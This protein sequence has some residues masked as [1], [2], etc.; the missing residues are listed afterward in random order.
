MLV[1]S[2][3][4]SLGLRVHHLAQNRGQNHPG[5][6]AAR[7]N[8]E[9]LRARL[10]TIVAKLGAGDSNR[11]A[12][13]QLGGLFRFLVVPGPGDTRHSSGPVFWLLCSTV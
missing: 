2:H 10:A 5:R 13:L 8:R 7:A 12:S 3:L 1:A 4:P 11:V 9:E 6:L